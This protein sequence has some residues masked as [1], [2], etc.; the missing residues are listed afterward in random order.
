MSIDKI[1]NIGLDKLIT[2]VYDFDSLT[3]DELMCKFA[4]KINIIIEHFKYLDEQCQNNN[5]NVKLKLEYLLG[6][7]LNEKVAERLLQL[8]NDGTIGNLINETLLK[9]INEQL[10]ANAN[11][12]DEVAQTGTT[13]E[14]VQNKVSEMAQNGSIT[15]NTVTPEMTTFIDKIG[16]SNLYSNAGYTDNKRVNENGQLVDWNYC[17]TLNL[18][19]VKPNTTY[20]FSTD[21]GK[22]SFSIKYLV[23]KQYEFL[24]DFRQTG[25]IEDATSIT[26]NEN[27][28]YLGISIEKHVLTAGGG[29]YATIDDFLNDFVIQESESNE[30][31]KGYELNNISVPY[32]DLELEKLNELNKIKEQ[33]ATLFG[34]SL[35]SEPVYQY[36]NGFSNWIVSNAGYNMVGGEIYSYN[37]NGDVIDKIE[38]SNLDAWDT[39]NSRGEFNRCTKEIDLSVADWW[40][41]EDHESDTALAFGLWISISN[42]E[43]GNVGQGENATFKTNSDLFVKTYGNIKLTENAMAY[44]NYMEGLGQCFYISVLKTNLETLD[45]VGLKKY[46]RDNNVKIKVKLKDN[47]SNIDTDPI[48]VVNNGIISSSGGLNVKANNC[49][50]KKSNLHGKIGMSLGDS[51]S[52]LGKWQE[53]V[54]N[55]LG[56]K[57]WVN[58]AV[59]GQRVS[60][61]A[62]NV[63]AE[64]LKDVDFVTVM[65]YFNSYDCP[66]GTSKDLASNGDTDS[67]WSNYKYIINKIKTLKPSVDIVIMSAHKP[68]PPNITDSRAELVKQIAKYYS[69]PFIDLHN[70]AGFNEYTYSIYLYDDKIHSTDLGYEKEAKLISGELRRIFG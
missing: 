15:F 39:I 14:A 57:S 12:I 31:I 24:D 11:R 70:E 7:G 13:M 65:G 30:E 1:R 36:S 43:I 63:T 8:I 67:I 42:I 66:D 53:L 22:T 55:D 29:K 18:F 9:E 62:E 6:Q 68:A 20:S 54:S 26:T 35:Y 46:L 49:G 5:E 52:A 69:L 25:Y 21:N 23:Q 59:G 56:I 10:V 16:A 44:G 41:S 17:F 37:V 34:S 64:N 3:T 2:Q 61:F 51:L 28:Q 60:K 40:R 4:Q 32:I 58:L 33:I 48:Y 38:V 27:T 45:I 19:K 50:I 47:I